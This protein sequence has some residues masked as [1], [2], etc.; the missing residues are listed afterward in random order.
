MP[1]GMQ[2]QLRNIINHYQNQEDSFWDI[3]SALPVGVYINDIDSLNPSYINDECL[4]AVEKEEENWLKYGNPHIASLLD[5][6]RELPFLKQKIVDFN[7]QKNYDKNLQTMQSLRIGKKVKHFV[8]NKFF[9]DTNSFINFTFVLDE[10]IKLKHFLHDVSE[11]DPKR[12]TQLK[13]LNLLSKAEKRIL[14]LIG[15]G[16]TSKMVGERIFISIHTVNNHRKSIKRKLEIKNIRE[17]IEYAEL[18]DFMGYQFDL[19]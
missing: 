8:V 9:L 18:L 3:L 4:F 10:T 7:H 5:D 16:M 19:D 14:Y 11:P 6:P 12:E 15:S 17:W 1:I 13:K 2:I